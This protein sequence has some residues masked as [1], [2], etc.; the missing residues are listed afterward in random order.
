V[1]IA[2]VPQK[3]IDGVGYPLFSVVLNVNWRMRMPRPESDSTS[4]GAVLELLS[5]H[6]FEGMATAMELLINEVAKLER[7]EFLGAMP[8]E[9]TESRRGHANG[10]EAKTVKIRV[11]ELDVR[12]PQVRGL[13]P[14]EEGFYPKSLERGVRS[15]RALKLAI[16]E[17]YVQGVSTRKVAAITRELAV[18]TSARPTSRVPPPSS[19]RNSTAGTPVRSGACPTCCSTPATRR[20]DTV[21]RWSTAPCWS[22]SACVV[23]AGGR[24]SGSACRFPRLRFTGGTSSR[25]SSAA[26]STAS[27]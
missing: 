3:R 9:R 12:V 7:S 11:G 22:Q 6:G 5:E 17:M 19:T 8:H 26:A 2:G 21:G 20:S 10:F 13:A 18:S 27:R 4:F 16:A 23:T 25:A 1:S 24:C 15:E 14:G